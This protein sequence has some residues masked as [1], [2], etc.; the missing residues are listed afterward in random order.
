MIPKNIEEDTFKSG[1]DLINKLR[2]LNPE[3]VS[4][5]TV[6]DIS[7]TFLDYIMDSLDKEI[8]AGKDKGEKATEEEKYIMIMIQMTIPYIADYIDL[9]VGKESKAY[10]IIKDLYY[11]CRIALDI[12]DPL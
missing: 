5:I 6:A 7:P 11:K 8:T 4:N 2:I 10:N 3:Y 1:Y 9:T 12:I